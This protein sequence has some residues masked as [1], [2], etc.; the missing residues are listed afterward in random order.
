MPGEKKVV[1]VFPDGKIV[2]KEFGDGYAVLDGYQHRC[3]F[4]VVQHLGDGSE[5]KMF[6]VNEPGSFEKCEEILD[7]VDAAAVLSNGGVG[8]GKLVELL[9]NIAEKVEFVWRGMKRSYIPF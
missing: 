5:M 2:F 6:V 8:V 4:I 1:K 3:V 7:A 9:E